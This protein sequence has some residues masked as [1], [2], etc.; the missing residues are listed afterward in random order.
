MLYSYPLG[1]L[2]QQASHTGHCVDLHKLVWNSS[3]YLYFLKR[4]MN[5]SD[6]QVTNEMC[7]LSHTRRETMSTLS[8]KGRYIIILISGGSERGANMIS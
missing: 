5:I 6:W 1:C 7:K 3:G 4:N 8:L 2:V